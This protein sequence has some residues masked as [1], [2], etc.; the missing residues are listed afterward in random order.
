MNAGRVSAT[1]SFALLLLAVLWQMLLDPPQRMPLALAPANVLFALRRPAAGFAAGVGAL[2]LFCHGVM[3]A[4]GNAP[5]RLWAWV[6]IALSVA[7]VFAAS[8]DGLRARFA[9]RRAAR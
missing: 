4:W 8:F 3:E 7:L 2:F 5:M 6:E 1:L 9:K